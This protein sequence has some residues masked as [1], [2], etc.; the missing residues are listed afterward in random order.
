MGQTLLATRAAVGLLLGRT[1]RN[2]ASAPRPARQTPIVSR[3][4]ETISMN[5]RWFCGALAFLAL[6]MTAVM[7][8]HAQVP[9]LLRVAWASIERPNPAS[10]YLE[11][12]R[13][14]M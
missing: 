13:R 7:P 14:G 6:G 5:R 12:F 4:T 1:S 10:P 3:S 9:R 8:L 11:A 2:V